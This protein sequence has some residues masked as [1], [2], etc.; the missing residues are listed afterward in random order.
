MPRISLRRIIWPCRRVAQN[1]I[2]SAISKTI[3]LPAEIDFD[4]FKTVY[5]QAYQS[6]CKG[7]TTY[8]PNAI[9][10]SVL[11]AEETAKDTENKK[12]EV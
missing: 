2:D 11:E 6:G 8:R 4:A 5:T 1:S 3:N 9:T 10:G 12:N 7:C